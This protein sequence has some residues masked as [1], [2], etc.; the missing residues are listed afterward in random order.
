[1]TELRILAID[2]AS[3]Q[4]GMR[5]NQPVTVAGLNSDGIIQVVSGLISTVEPDHDRPPSIRTA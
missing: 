3:V 4:R 5:T 1:M 2:L